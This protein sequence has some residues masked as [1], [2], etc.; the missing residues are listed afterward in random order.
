L[1]ENGS[2]DS[3]QFVSPIR[4]T[5]DRLELSALKKAEDSDATIL[6]LYE[7]HGDRGQAVIESSSPLREALLVNI[8]EE[9]IKPLQIEEKKRVRLP[10]TPFEVLTV[11]LAH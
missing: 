6:R 11:N 9:P 2:S 7:P 3:A 5:G 10:F 8:L 4:L 1:L